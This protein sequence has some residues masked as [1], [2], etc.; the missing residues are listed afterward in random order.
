MNRAP[1]IL[2]ISHWPEE[3]EASNKKTHLA[4]QGV[5]MLKPSIAYC[6]AA[7]KDDCV[8]F[9]ESIVASKDLLGTC[10][11]WFK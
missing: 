5:G 1:S 7:G 11:M 9:V 8:S 2:S 3:A 6:S 10:S 4:F